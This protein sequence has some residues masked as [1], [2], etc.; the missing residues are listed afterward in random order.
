ML[1]RINKKSDLNFS[2][3]LFPAKTDIAI[4]K[5]KA[6]V[7]QMCELKPDFF[8]IT[9][10]AGGSTKDATFDLVKYIKN[11]TNIDV[12]AH[13]TCVGS[14]KKDI[15]NIAKSYLDIGVNKI[16]A[17]RG[18]APKSD[19]FFKPHPDG[20]RYADELVEGLLDISNDFEISVASYPETHPESKNSQD[21]LKFL[22]K[23][24][25]AGSKDTITQYCIE[26]DK[27]INFINDA[28]QAGIS[29]E[30]IPGIVLMNGFKQFVSFSKMCGSSVPD[31][32]YDLFDYDN[33]DIKQSDILSFYLAYEQCKKLID[34]GINNFHFYSLN[35]IDQLSPLLKLLK[36]YNNS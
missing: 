10:G 24:L 21:D 30:I 7:H 13:L 33:E 27:I 31:Y 9:Y 36:K 3:E 26:T 16:V 11:N 8:S 2:I 15:E 34:F 25:D 6:L 17:L 18:D 1:Q 22:K 4:E 19:K 5:L 35:R 28:R 20:Y 32:L 12:A 23:K 29:K 14:S